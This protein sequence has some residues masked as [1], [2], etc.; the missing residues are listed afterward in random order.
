[1]HGPL[2]Y[3]QPLHIILIPIPP[4]YTPM[5]W[6][7]LHPRVRHTQHSTNQHN[8]PPDSI[9]FITKL[10]L[11]SLPL[12]SLLTHLLI[13]LLRRVLR[14]PDR[15]TTDKAQVEPCVLVLVVD[16]QR[17]PTHVDNTPPKPLHQ[18]TPLR[19]A[20]TTTPRHHLIHTK[21]TALTAPQEAAHRRCRLTLNRLCGKD[22]Q[23]HHHH[24]YH[25]MHGPP[26]C[27][28]PLHMKVPG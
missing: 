26:C 5:A 11:D 8:A 23:H 24:D 16:L 19:Y 1:M 7:H 28:Q 15:P 12:P 22:Q 6:A 20:P 18:S 21:Y 10:P 27:L 17:L 14:A 25:T 9:H 2:C 3:L 4:A 13:A